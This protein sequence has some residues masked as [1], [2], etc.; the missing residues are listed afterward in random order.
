[1]K[2]MRQIQHEMLTDCFADQ[3]SGNYQSGY[4]RPVHMGLGILAIANTPEEYERLMDS[5]DGDWKIFVWAGV[6]SV[7]FFVSVAGILWWMQ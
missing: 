5:M 2:S 6:I 7:T 4:P 3:E 1:M